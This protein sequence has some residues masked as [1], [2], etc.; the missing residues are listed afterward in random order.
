MATASHAQAVKSLNKSPGRRRF[1]FKRFSQKLEEIDIDVYRSLDKIK[2]EPSEG[3]SFFRDCLIEWR[4]LNTAEDFISFYEE[5]MPFVQTLPLVLLH[6]ESVISKLLFRLQ[7]N[8]RLSIDPVLRLIAALSRDLQE[9][10]LC[11]LPRI[12][13]SLVSLL[14]SGADREPEIIEQI[15]TSWSYIMMYLQKYLARDIINLLSVTLNLRYYPRDYVQEYM[16]QALSFL[17]RRVSKEQ[18]E[19]GVRKLMFEVVEEPLLPRKSGVGALL[20]Y[21]MKGTS[22]RFHS[23]ADRIVNLLTDDS[24]FSVGDNLVKG[25]DAVVEV[26]IVAFQRL[27]EE[28]EPEEL[29]WMW[30][31]VCRRIN[32]CVTTGRLLHLCRLLL[33][34]ISTIQFNEG[35]SVFDYHPILKC[36]G[37]LVQ[38]YIMPS[39]SGNATEVHSSEVVDKVLQLML[40]ILDGLYSSGDMSSIYECSLEWAPAFKL[41]NSSLLSFIKELLLKDTCILHMFKV[42]I[43]SS[44]ND[45]IETY[46]E[47]V[48]CL[49]LSFCEKMQENPQSCS[50]FDGISEEG[51]SRVCSFLQGAIYS[52]IQVVNSIKDG[53]WS[54]TFI[55]EPKL[56]LLWG[57]IRCYS[58]ISNAQVTPS[59]LMDLVDA[60]DQLL[61]ID[62]ENI[63]GASRN[64]WTSL[65]AAALSSY[66]KG[67]FYKQ[68]GL[69]ETRKALRLA[70]SYNLSSQVLSAVAD[71]LDHTSGHTLQSDT[72]LGISHP[73]LQAEKVVDAVG[74]FAGNLCKS[75]KGIRVTT[76]RILCHYEPLKCEPIKDEQADTKVKNDASQISHLDINNNN[77]LRLLLSIEETPISISTSRTVTLLISKIQMALSTGRVSKTYI[78]LVLNGL[79]GIFH[80][81]FNYLWNPASECLAVLIGKHSDLVWDNFVGYVEYCQSTF[82]TLGNQQARGNDKISDES[83][84]LVQHFHLFVD[85]AS[86]STP[87]NTVLSLLLQTSQ[88]ISSIVESRSRQIV[89]LFLKFLGYKSDAMLSVGSFNASTCKGKEW[90]D[91][92]KEWLNLLRQMRNLKSSYCSHLLKDVLHVRLLDEND[93]EIQMKVLDCLLMWK[94]D[95]LLPYDQHLKNLICSKQFREEL[96]TWSLDRE[97]SLIEEVHRVYLVPHVIRILMPKV[98]KLKTIASRKRMSMHHRKAV[99]GFIAQL[100]VDEIPLFFAML[101]KPLHIIPNETDGTTNL[102]WTSFNTGTDELRLSNCLKYFTRENILAL[103]WKKKYALLH[104]IEDILVVFDELHISPFLEFLMGCVVRIL[105]SCSSSIDAAKALGSSSHV[106]NNS[107]INL[108]LQEEEKT[109]SNHV[110][111]HATLKQL[112]DMRSLSLKIVSSVLNKYEHHDFGCD[113][114]DLFFTS[115]KPLIDGFKQE[116]SSS[117]KP[118]SL[119]SCF[120][121]MSRS[122]KLVLLLYRDKNLVGNIFSILTVTT[123]S[124]AVVKCVL[125]FI[126]NLLNLDSEL[127]DMD[128]SVR[129]NLLSNLEALTSGLHCL[130]H[131]DSAI[132]R[133]LVKHPGEMEIRIFK[134]LS[135]YIS[136]P[137][138]ARKFIDILLPFLTKRVQN[139]G[140]YLE[141]VQAIRDIIPV[142]GSDI[143]TKILNAVSPLLVSAE[144][145]IRLGICDLLDA[146]AKSDPSVAFMAKLIH[147]L[148]ATSPMEMGGLDYSVI[149][150]AYEKIGDDLFYTIQEDQALV[151]LSHCVYDMSSEE[152]ILRNSA[153]RS[154]LSFVEFSKMILGQEEI[155]NRHETP[156]MMKISKGCGTGACVQ[157]IVSKFLLKHVADAMSRARSVKKEWIEL[158]REMVLKLPELEN[159]NSLK[160][161]CSEDAEQDFFNNIVHI[162][163][164]RRARALSRFRNVVSMHNISEVQGIINKVFVPLFFNML[165][166]VQNGKG[167][168]IRN[169]CVEALGSISGAMNWR[170]YYALLTRCFREMDKNPDKQ[171][172]LLRLICSVLGQ[173]HFSVVDPSKIVKDRLENF[174]GADTMVTDS[175]AQLKRNSSS[176]MVADIQTCL[177][178]TLLPKIQ[179]V[180]NS[181]SDKVNVTIFV[182]ALKVLKLLPTDIMDS[183]LPNVIHR[184][185]N[186]LKNRLQS[187]RDEARSALAACLKELGLEYLQFIVR[188]LR[189]T[190]KRGFELHVLGYTLNFILSQF[191]SDPISGKLDYCLE[192]LLSV[193]ENDILGDVAEEKEV[194]KIASRMKETRKQKSFDTLKMVA[195][196]VTFKIHAEKLLSPVTAHM[197][198]FRIPKVRAKLESML[199]HVAAGIEHNPSVNQTDLFIFIYGLIEDGSNEETGQLEKLS[200]GNTKNHPTTIVNAK[201]NS[202]QTISAKSACS[203]LITVFALGMLRNRIKNI[204]SDK[205]GE[206]LSMLDPFVKL[207]G[208]CL[209]SK[210][211]DVLSASLRCLTP[212]IRLPLPSLES[213]ADKI[214]MTLLDIA[215]SSVSSSSPLTESCLRLLTVLLR[216]TKIT[217]SSD[218]LHLLIQ[219]PLFVDLEKNPSFV[220]LSLL[221]AIVSRKLV[222]HE[223]YDIVI[224]VAEL[225]V[226]SQVES[227]RK[228]CSQILLQ[229]LLDY[230]LSEKR[231]Q[232]HLDFLL[233]NLRYEHST[234]REAV[235]E[236]LHAIIMKFPKSILDEQSQTVFVHLVVSL[237]ND[238]DNK[239][240]SMTG[241]VIKHLIGRIEPHSLL[242]I[243]QYSLSWYLGEKQ[244]LWSTGAQVLGLLV[245]VMDDSF[246]VHINSVLPVIRRI[247]QSAMNAV[248]NRQLDLSDENNVHF[249]KEAYYSLVL[250]EKL[251]HHLHNLSFE[252]DLEDIWEAVCEFLL[253]PHA[254]LRNISSRLVALYFA[255]ATQ[256]G[257][258]NHEKSLGSYFLMRPSRLFMIAVSLCCQ[259]K[260]LPSDDSAGNLITQNIV[261]ATCA[262]H[263]LMGQVEC[264]HPHKF[265]SNLEQH[266]QGQFLKAFQLLDSRKERGLLLSLASGAC[267]QREGVDFENLRHLLVSCLLKTMGAIS[268]NMEAAQM[269]IVF[270][271]FQRISSQISQDDCQQ[272]AFQLLLPL[273]KVCE[274]YSGK[275][276]PDDL[277]QLAEEVCR[278]IRDSLGIQN[279]VHVYNEIRRNL[280]A[281]RD[282]RRQEDKVMAV[283]NPTRNAKRKLRI[284]AK[285][286]DHKRRKI[287][288][289]KMGRWMK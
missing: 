160:N 166:D 97:S 250:L 10:F 177:H 105:E 201:A 108:T 96:T 75:D 20:C 49:L 93:A 86:D 165:I 266:E 150:N 253:H 263:A 232:Q 163:K 164:H 219:F 159:L 5:I 64:I 40:C 240:R 66:Y 259:L 285:H 146:L 18:L 288:S 136:G 78:P 220:A 147:E 189:A 178:K 214:K 45:L 73:E 114:W 286:R 246:Q 199:K 65:I 227:I 198:K 116:G 182:V 9:D 35:R 223:I 230:H 180:L 117:E 186:Y 12:V 149:L 63:A 77:V 94:D 22:S 197:Q 130:F 275:V 140:F 81:R 215:Q 131:S 53:N 67:N 29:N 210:Y 90:K 181:D 262:V 8:A 34:L 239:V 109:V 192:D 137:S 112:K 41:R 28:L 32:D 196:T 54:S 224:Q 61:K 248:A 76:I 70:K 1:V 36:V 6:K 43:L 281:K 103:S 85:P 71:Y 118:S 260:T 171:K 39:E 278:S 128:T 273:Y 135:K 120:M 156:E 31:F 274:G 218:Q 158:L 271:T 184:I 226:T 82:Q 203:H 195:Q 251:L 56:A 279:F 231:L 252:K 69:E 276:I 107:S 282:K 141:A 139:S 172:V 110:Q 46:G 187:I 89:P 83:S 169:A 268:L 126:D 14:N 127:E 7:M 91:V 168:N 241:T 190:L 44:M 30:E 264:A 113:F 204:K 57:S 15:F 55:E 119:F 267:Y 254:W 202:R 261:F 125:K 4:E 228:K 244:Q 287:M 209:S 284:S 162:Q 16:A 25:L 95:F 58:Y 175:S 106:D 289:M 152:I 151:I 100:D 200:T 174:S 265:W 154:L 272:Y 24:I 50:L 38:T 47:E 236:M 257:R 142:L 217:L 208:I 245:E 255:S 111:N 194:E 234:G 92:L 124:E 17:L 51:F 173:F 123:A 134:L 68:S 33:L 88:K 213:Q 98:R 19:K 207:L 176:P 205:N 280:K 60:L 161:L 283:V 80:N 37:L 211:E 222:V 145:D 48:T 115:I 21:A 129:V 121:A 235:L 133:K 79:I 191:I 249:W 72:T 23:K 3:S 212:L 247:L 269:R 148:N 52:W 238:T 11:F 229:F 193:I 13:D 206:L 170:S 143:T 74:I 216:C 221:K 237:A 233:A 104:V 27:C 62:G 277:K 2:S 101:M 157:R 183:L 122:H 242:S 99:L 155:E 256:A 42:D 243:L 225:M 179:K 167:E 138:L 102:F 185:S 87:C 270:N 153:Y 59:V 144:L 84:D 26:V 132:K 188:V 258:E